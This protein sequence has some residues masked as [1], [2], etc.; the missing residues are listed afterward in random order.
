MQLMAAVETEVQF[1]ASLPIEKSKVRRQEF[2]A[3]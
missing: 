2:P 3:T 1:C